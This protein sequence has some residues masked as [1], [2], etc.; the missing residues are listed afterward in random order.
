MP[1]PTDIIASLTKACDEPV[2]TLTL[3]AR[4]LRQNDLFVRET[5]SPSSWKAAPSDAAALLLSVMSGLS[6]ARGTIAVA[7]CRITKKDDFGDPIQRGYGDIGKWQAAWP[8]QFVQALCFTDNFFD[9]VALTIAAY[10]SSQRYMAHH[11][12]AGFNVGIEFIPFRYGELTISK[13]EAPGDIH[14]EQRWVFQDDSERPQ[15]FDIVTGGK[16]TDETLVRL[17]EV[18]APDWSADQPGD[19]DA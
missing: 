4:F 9:A 18:F 16:C 3:R 7:N 5:K 8:E 1:R 11:I 12:H 13:R 19:D 10:N 14:C 17:A 15:K 2:Q 6:A